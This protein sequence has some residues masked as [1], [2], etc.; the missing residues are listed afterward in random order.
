L[1]AN[2]AFRDVDLEGRAILVL[3]LLAPST[4]KVMRMLLYRA[5]K[6]MRLL[7]TMLSLSMALGRHR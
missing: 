2:Q 6:L 1:Q 3:D 5:S 4:A 7:E